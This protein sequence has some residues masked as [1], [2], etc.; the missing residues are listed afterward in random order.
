MGL[1]QST[2]APRMR[3]TDQTIANYE[4]GKTQPGAADPHLRLLFLM[5]ILPPDSPAELIKELMDAIASFC[6]EP[7]PDLPRRKIG[8]GWEA[9]QYAAC[10]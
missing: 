7:M 1:T 4:K 9:Q 3:V 8:N 2:L 6:P 5:H 10:A